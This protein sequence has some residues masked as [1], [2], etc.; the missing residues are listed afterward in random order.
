MTKYFKVL[1]WLEGTSLLT[2]LLVAMPLKY[3]W[4]EPKMVRIVG[5]CHGGLFLLYVLLATILFEQQNWPRKKLVMAYFLSTM[6]FGTFIFEWKYLHP[7]SHEQT[8]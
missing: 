5:S 2:L 6:P 1:G 8:V 4:H 3:I 7:H